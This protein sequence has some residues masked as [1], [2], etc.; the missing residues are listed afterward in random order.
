MIESS[1]LP[2]TRMPLN[3]GGATCLQMNFEGLNQAADTFPLSRTCH[4]SAAESH[5]TSCGLEFIMD[6]HSI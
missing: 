4:T 6:V 1:D 2:L 5:R 3:N